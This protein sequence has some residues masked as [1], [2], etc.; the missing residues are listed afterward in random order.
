MG[1]FNTEKDDGFVRMRA[2]IEFRDKVMGGTPMNPEV[3]AA[4]IRKNVHDLTAQE[5][6]TTMTKQAILDTYPELVEEDFVEDAT[7]EDIIA[8]IAKRRQGV[9]FRRDEDGI[10]LEDRQIKA[11]LK[12]VVNIRLAGS[13]M[14]KTRKGPKNFVAER[15]FV[16]E[17]KIRFSDHTEP[18]G[19]ELFVGH[20][21]GPQGTMS[22][23]TNYE[24][25]ERGVCEFTLMMTE[26][27]A[28]ELEDKWPSLWNLAQE[29]GL[30]ALRSQSHG[31]FD[32]TAWDRV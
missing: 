13:R 5:E 30:G 7:V 6:I 1:I 17:A 18:D 21:S 8:K 3:V 19:E 10:F 16:E 27:A 26:D 28:E 23:L 14:G 31:R 12:E 15:V 29:N 20:P 2:R 32:L 25:V 4:W 9:G 11:M 22:T 24:Y